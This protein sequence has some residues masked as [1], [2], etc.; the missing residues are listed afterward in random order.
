M[1]DKFIPTWFL[2]LGNTFH[3]ASLAARCPQ[4]KEIVCRVV[5]SSV[6]SL[7]LE[8]VRL[9]WHVIGRR[10]RGRLKAVC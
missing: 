4:A 8:V 2:L 3:R 1:G 6:A 10:L 5:Q 7:N 9:N